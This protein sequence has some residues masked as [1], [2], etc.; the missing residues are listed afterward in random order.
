MSGSPPP[1]SSQLPTS[2]PGHTRPR[3][4]RKAP[5]RLGV[6]EILPDLVLSSD[7]GE[8][9]SDGEDSDQILIQ[10]SPFLKP[11]RFSASHRG[12]QSVILSASPKTPQGPPP[13]RVTGPAFHPL[14]FNLSLELSPGPAFVLPP[15][16]HQIQ[17]DNQEAVPVQ[18]GGADHSQQA[19]PNLL[20]G[21]GPQFQNDELQARA[22]QEGVL[23]AL[24]PALGLRQ[25]A[26]E[27][28]AQHAAAQLGRPNPPVQV[29]QQQ[30]DGDQVHVVQSPPGHREVA[31]TVGEQALLQDLM[32]P[33]VPG[34]HPGPLVH[35]ADGWNMIDKWGVWQCVLC[36]FP[37]LLDI[38]RCYR[39]VWAKAVSRVLSVIQESEG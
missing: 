8:S 23:P 35:D 33:D 38:P 39:D 7:E 12:R 34:P 26:L 36:E 6:S 4:S 37:T 29:D 13:A 32:D 17:R 24:Q 16:P 5:D 19:A 18:Q 28:A 27:A 15:T 1:R 30:G 2:P 3:R 20:G 22:V 11:Q 14:P 9:D 25:A 21:T 10:P 31:G